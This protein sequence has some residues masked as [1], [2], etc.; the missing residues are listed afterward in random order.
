M[1]RLGVFEMFLRRPA[2]RIL[3]SAVLQKIR[4]KEM[5][6]KGVEPLL[7]TEPD[8][9][10]GASANSATRARRLAYAYCAKLASA[11]PRVINHDLWV[12]SACLFI[13]TTRDMRRDRDRF[14]GRKAEDGSETA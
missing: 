8:P 6:G 13:P 14:H 5:L 9:K 11:Q 10:S 12:L 1:P 7:L 3:D 2:G 4:A